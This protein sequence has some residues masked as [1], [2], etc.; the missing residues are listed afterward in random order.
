M[1]Y[2]YLI[3]TKRDAARFTCADDRDYFS[4]PVRVTV[5]SCDVSTRLVRVRDE[6]RGHEYPCSADDLRPHYMLSNKQKQ[7]IAA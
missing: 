2:H 5:L 1:T 7:M 4:R 3:T 6:A